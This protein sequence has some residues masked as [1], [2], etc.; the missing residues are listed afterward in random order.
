MNINDTKVM[1]RPFA[2]KDY[3]LRAQLVSL[4]FPLSDVYLLT[5]LTACH[6]RNIM[7]TAVKEQNWESR[8]GLFVV[9]YYF[10]SFCCFAYYHCLSF[11]SY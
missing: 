5:F 2:E 7:V 10:P 11:F 3:V 1:T 8:R 4:S 6:Y 9:N